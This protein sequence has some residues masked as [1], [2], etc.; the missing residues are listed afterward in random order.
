V[1]QRVAYGFDPVIPRSRASVIVAFELGNADQTQ[2]AADDEQRRISAAAAAR[3]PEARW[4]KSILPA[5]T[6]EMG[7]D[8]ESDRVK[9]CFH[10][11][12]LVAPAMAAIAKARAKSSRLT[13]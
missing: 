6:Q 4:D 3:Y 7:S 5:G 13:K 8:M 1:D 9:P 10:I 11:T 2:Q 12:K